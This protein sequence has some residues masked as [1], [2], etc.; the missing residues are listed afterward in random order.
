MS[1]SATVADHHATSHATAHLG[2]HKLAMK[3]V[4]KLLLEDK[5][6]SRDDA[7]KAMEHRH[8]QKSGTHPLVIIAD[9]KFKSGQPPHKL[10]HLEAL[11]EW[12]AGKLC[13]EYF[14]IDPLK[15]NFATVTEVMPSAYAARL[16]VL[17]VHVTSAEV[18]IATAEPFVRDWEPELH[19]VIKKTIRRVLANPQDIERFQ[20]EFYKLA[21]S[22]KKAGAADQQQ[23]SQ[24]EATA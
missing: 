23:R 19:G 3:E 2:E 22:V 7:E 6:I 5:M 18:T 4:L 15:I 21:A 9:Q 17:P 10:L 11:T 14:H 1:K 8:L 13:M 12:L 24:A 20:I 16:K